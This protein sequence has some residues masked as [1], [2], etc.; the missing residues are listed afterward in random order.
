MTDDQS[1]C[2]ARVT[3]ACHQLHFQFRV[4][5]SESSSHFTFL[6]PR[7]S[8]AKTRRCRQPLDLKSI[9]SKYNTGP[10]ICRPFSVIAHAD[11]QSFGQPDTDLPDDPVTPVTPH[12]V[13]HL[14][15]RPDGSGHMTEAEQ[16]EMESP[17]TQTK[18]VLTHETGYGTGLRPGS[19]STG[20]TS[21][22]A[23]S[24]ASVPVSQVTPLMH[25]SSGRSAGT[26][27]TPPA[28]GLSAKTTTPV[29]RISDRTQS[30]NSSAS[31]TSPLVELR[32][33]RNVTANRSR[34][35][36]IRQSSLISAGHIRNRAS[37][38]MDFMQE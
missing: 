9:I 24:A 38:K 35:M 20:R 22:S 3:I 12:A 23:A 28:S 25:M 34:L 14:F 31:D 11:Q 13:P 8:K 37:D 7:V 27:F 19:L 4:C 15:P 21:A 29:S 30:T 17:V 16:R 33:L 5:Q 1:E 18:S 2:D 36:E 32:E 26:F 10:A 6:M